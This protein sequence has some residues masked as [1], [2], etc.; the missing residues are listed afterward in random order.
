[1]PASH[2]IVDGDTVARLA[3]AA[4]LLPDTVWNDPAND[5]LRETREHPNLLVPGDVLVIPDRRVKEVTIATGK[6]HTFV[7]HSVPDEFHE[8]F[9]DRDGKPREGVAYLVSVDSVA[10]E[11]AKLGADGGIRIALHP[12]ACEVQVELNDGGAVETY[13]FRVGFLLPL[14]E[15][16]G[17]QQRLCSLGHVC[18]TDGAAGEE[19]TAALRAFQNKHGLNET[20]EAD[21]ATKEALRDQFGA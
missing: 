18:P 10:V 16:R 9:L 14:S 3:A 8:R 7:R 15:L 11:Q 12:G 21:D 17:V 4:G 20:G 6:A 5:A 13:R 2:T 19:T 1:M